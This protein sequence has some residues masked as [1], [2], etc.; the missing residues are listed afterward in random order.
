MNILLSNMEAK[1][2][3]DEHIGFSINILNTRDNSVNFP[4]MDFFDLEL[5]EL[6]HNIP[7]SGARICTDNKLTFGKGEESLIAYAAVSNNTVAGTGYIWARNLS[8][9]SED[10]IFIQS[11]GGVVLVPIAYAIVNTLDLTGQVFELE[12][13]G[14]IVVPPMRGLRIYKKLFNERVRTIKTAVSSG[15]L[16]TVNGG[17][18][19]PAEHLFFTLSSTG[20]YAPSQLKEARLQA[21]ITF[22][23]MAKMGINPDLVGK[24]RPLSA[25]SNHIA[26][27]AN[28]ILVG[29]SANDL[30]PI[31]V[32]KFQYLEPIN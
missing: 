3:Y 11:D 10:K 23:G 32:Q 30:G 31:Y 2:R 29:F 17:K 21:G 7:N 4:Y 14:A 12:L 20:N 8:T 6:G 5:K 9:A 22:E 13:G 16:L 26:Q 27:Q 18:A 15:E 19:I 1:T 25:G 24:P 28:M